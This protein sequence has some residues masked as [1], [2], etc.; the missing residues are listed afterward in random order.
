MV[1][2]EQLSVHH[3]GLQIMMMRKKEE[4]EDN[5]PEEEENRSSI[6]STCSKSTV[7]VSGGTEEQ[8]D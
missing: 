6:G 7:S 8:G 3:C 1:L 4:E 5:Q 2:M